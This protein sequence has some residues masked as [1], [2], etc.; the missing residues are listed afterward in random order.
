MH[1]ELLAEPQHAAL[2]DAAR[3]EVARDI[4]QRAARRP[5]KCMHDRRRPRRPVSQSREVG[6]RQG[7]QRVR[8]RTTTLAP[9]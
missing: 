9:R 8:E 5:L 2:D 3:V 7:R 4:G 6:D 1:V